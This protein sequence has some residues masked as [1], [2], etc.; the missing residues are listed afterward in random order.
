MERA[1]MAALLP[2]EH[3][4]LRAVPAPRRL[5]G[6]STR[7][8]R[9]C[10]IQGKPR[11]RTGDAGEHS[12]AHRHEAGRKAIMRKHLAIA[13]S[14]ALAAAPGAA[15]AQ[16]HGGGGGGGWHGGG[17]HGG[18]WHGGGGHGGGWHGGGGGWHGGGWHGGGHWRGGVSVYL[19]PSLYWGPVY[20]PYP[21]YY[22]DYPAPAYVAP[23]AYQYYCPGVG[24]YPAV[25]TCAQP[26]LRVLPN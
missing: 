6:G 3:A 13:F 10:I 14:L 24:Y 18:G 9:R 17:G 7:A 22:Y 4:S 8:R 25:P 20:D 11:A 5:A 19:G 16:H 26:W 2:Y 23:P 12:N 1:I 15:L 21:A